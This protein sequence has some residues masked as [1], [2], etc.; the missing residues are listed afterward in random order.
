M[1]TKKDEKKPAAKEVK[2]PEK[3]VKAPKVVQPIDPNTHSERLKSGVVNPMRSEVAGIK[4]LD[5]Q[6]S[7]KEKVAEMKSNTLSLEEQV[8]ALSLKVEALSRRVP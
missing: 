7:L 8:A 2:A 4:S 6:I 1:S 3:E 5:H